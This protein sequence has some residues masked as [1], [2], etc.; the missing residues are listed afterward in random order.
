MRIYYVFFLFVAKS[1]VKNDCP[2]TL[3][4]PILI[5]QFFRIAIAQIKKFNQQL[6]QKM[7]KSISCG[8]FY[9]IYF[10]SAQK[11]QL[12][13]QSKILQTI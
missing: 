13:K 7:K 12:Q 1:I 4:K 2:V 6:F 8:L 10:D 3:M 5:D 9:F 11:E